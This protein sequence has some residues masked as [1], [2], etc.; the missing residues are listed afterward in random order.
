M[1]ENKV[2]ED[3]HIY[4]NKNVP[5]QLELLRC[6]AQFVLCEGGMGSG[7]S[8][9]SAFL[10][11]MFMLCYKNNLGLA[12]AETYP[13]VTDL[14]IPQ[15]LKI[16]PPET[17][18]RYKLS[19]PQ[20]IYLRNGSEI[21]F[22]QIEEARKQKGPQYGAILIEEGSNVGR[23]SYNILISR[24]RLTTVPHQM[25]LISTNPEPDSPVAQMFDEQ[26]DNPNY[27]YFHSKTSDNADNLPDNYEYNLRIAY[28]DDLVAKYVDGKRVENKG[29]FYPTFS[30]RLHSWGPGNVLGVK[31]PPESFDD[32]IAGA[33]KGFSKPGCIAVIGIKDGEFWLLDGVYTTHQ[34]EGWWVVEAQRLYEKWHYTYFWVDSADP[35]RVQAYKD[36]GL[37]SR[38][39][40]KDKGSVLARLDRL[41]KYLHVRPDTGRARF[42]YN[43]KLKDFKKEMAG[44][45]RKKKPKTDNEYYEEPPLDSVDHYI[46]AVTYALYGYFKESIDWSNARTIG[47]K[48]EFRDN[49]DG[50]L[51]GQGFDSGG[52]PGG[53]TPGG[54]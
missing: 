30:E 47:K 32:V 16:L 17:I 13:V 50:Y 39:S 21:R 36:A 7:K 4:F 10:F 3:V 23:A 18:H 15:I 2:E 5:W 45:K 22:R 54:Y 51:S 33:D 31:K 48:D 44:F 43:P 27:A 6:K 41:A 1:L 49:I 12:A 42:Y 26:K 29:K 25:M 9:G 37:D 52:G 46:D 40:I 24:L 20:T 19:H 14:V 28:D 35:D 53:H 11:I 38:P 8:F 34:L